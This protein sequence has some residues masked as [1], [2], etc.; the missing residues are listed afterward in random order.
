M[1]TLRVPIPLLT[2]RNDHA[3]AIKKN[4][5]ITISAVPVGVFLFPPASFK[6]PKTQTEVWM[7]AAAA[8][9]NADSS[10]SRSAHGATG[11]VCNAERPHGTPR[12]TPARRCH[13]MDQENANRKSGSTP[14]DPFRSYS[15]PSGST[16]CVSLRR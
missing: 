5:K 4:P 1:E 16:A 15:E 12:A 8:A 3:S 13:R 14:A 11:L 6:G 10:L 2:H 7:A 9:G